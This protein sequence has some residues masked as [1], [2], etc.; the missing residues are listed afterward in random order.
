MLEPNN[1]IRC[2]FQKSLWL[3]IVFGVFQSASSQAASCS[4]SIGK[5]AI[6]EVLTTQVTG[7][8]PFV[9]LYVP[10]DFSIPSGWTLTVNPNEGNTSSFTTVSVPNGTYSAGSFIVISFT[11][12]E[13]LNTGND[14]LLKDENGDSVDFLRF[15]GNKSP[16]DPDCGLLDIIRFAHS[17]SEKDVCSI[18]DGSGNW[19]DCASGPTPGA[20]NATGP[21]SCDLGG[22]VVSAAATALACP[23]ARSSFTVTALCSDL[24]STK[25]DYV[26]TVSLS[27]SAGIGSEFYSASS[28]GSEI[29][30]YTFTGSD[31]GLATLY[32]YH[33]DEA[34]ITVTVTDTV[35]NPDISASSGAVDF[36]AF[37]FLSSTLSSSIAACG[38]SGG[39]SLTAIGQVEGSSGCSVIEG[40]SGSKNVK[41][42]SE[43]VSP[44]SNSSGSQVSVNGSD[45]PTSESSTQS[46][47][48]NNGVASY[49]VQYDDAGRIKLHFKH[50]QDPYDG[51]PYSAMET[52]TNEFVSVPYG[53][54][55]FSDQANA[56]C[57]SGDHSCSAFRKAGDDFSLKVRAVC[58]DADNTDLSDNPVTANF[59]QS[60]I[61]LSHNLIAPVGGQPGSLGVGSFSI[62]EADDGEHDV[63]NQTVSEVG[64]FT[65]TAAAFT[66]ESVSPLISSATSANIGRFY[67]DHF[68]LSGASLTNRS[69]IGSCTDTYSYMGETFNTLFTLVAE[70]V[71]NVTTANYAGDF[72]KLDSYA[73]LNLGA[74]DSGTDLSSRL[75]AGTNPASLTWPAVGASGAG[76]GVIDVD[77]QLNRAGT[78]DGPYNALSVGV[79]PNDGDAQLAS[80]DLDVDGDSANERGLLGTSII[81]Y[82]RLYVKNAFGPETQDLPVP[83]QLQYFDG[84]GF[85]TNSDDS[86]STYIASNASLDHSSYGSDNLEVGDTS[87]SA[88]GSATAVA[89]GLSSLTTPLLL[90][91]PGAGKDGQ[92]DVTY[93]VPDWLKFDWFGGGDVNPVGQVTFGV[94]RGHDRIIY[95]KENFSQ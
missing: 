68:S 80:F 95:W 48:F 78:P 5:V 3:I 38:L 61:T 54:Y 14:V 17:A 59:Q 44:A 43:Y 24:S 29:T 21:A 90:Q 4:G 39:H 81:R 10:A 51:A 28:G 94:Y 9:E 42:W 33:N 45:V 27:T 92:V 53:L 58:S 26:G 37:G 87:V 34:S 60:N 36:R 52:E 35:P 19:S 64:V 63:S 6:N 69:D 72:A 56:S 49:S 65:F 88:P 67:P 15:G 7:V 18:P 62:S 71:G 84:S 50:D 12:S 76:I 74:V 31:N 32:L 77:L 82:G 55:V 20:T 11:S 47:S 83:L 89:S 93:S 73:E 30:D 46:L 41:I 57:V 91:A 23:S 1:A 70:N 75:A 16:L 79:A 2:W 13:L 8:P 22:F 85:V 66:Y 86:C 40:F 25:D